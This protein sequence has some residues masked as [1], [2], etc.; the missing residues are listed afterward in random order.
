M[1]DDVLPSSHL[2]VHRAKIVFAC[3]LGIGL[4]VSTASLVATHLWASLPAEKVGVI[5]FTGIAAATAIWKALSDTIE[6]GRTAKTGWRGNKFDHLKALLTLA[7]TLFGVMLPIFAISKAPP[8][9]K[10][11]LLDDLRDVVYVVSYNAY[12]IPSL[13]LD[14]ALIYKSAQ[15]TEPDTQFEPN[16]STERIRAAFKPG[17]V[18][19]IPAQVDIAKQRLKQLADRCAYKGAGQPLEIQIYGFSNDLPIVDSNKN[20]RKDSDQLNLLVANER[21]RSLHATLAAAAI[22]LYPSLKDELR[23]DWQPWESREQ[24]RAFRDERGFR[25]FHISGSSQIDQR[26][27]IMVVK[28]PG[29]C[30]VLARK[31]ES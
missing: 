14:P 4:G 1:A 20:P 19:L 27:A 28:T 23:L 2:G 6:L 11:G 16:E 26:S 9:Y 5:S 7:T 24:M 17:S 29:G 3:V 10:Q 31:P 15:L 18:D 8:I 12:D 21:G 13:L 25:N 22:E 30:P